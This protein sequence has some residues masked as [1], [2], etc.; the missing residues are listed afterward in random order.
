MAQFGRALR[1]G[2]RGRRFKS[3]HLDQSRTS[4][5][6]SRVEVFLFY[7]FNLA[8]EVVYKHSTKKVQVFEL[9]L[10]LFIL[11]HI[12]SLWGNIYM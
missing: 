7:G 1:S 11:L 2:R 5:R 8:F 12:T 9:G 3:C 4:T 6:N 10:F